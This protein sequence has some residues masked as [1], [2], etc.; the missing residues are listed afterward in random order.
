MQDISVPVVN[1]TI[2]V[3]FRPPAPSSPTVVLLHGLTGTSRWWSPVISHLPANIGLVVPDIRGRGQS[4]GSA[5]PFD[6]KTIADDIGHCLDHFEVEARTV[7]GYSMGAWVA[8]LFGVRHPERL[9]NILLVDGGLPV[10]FDA[11]LETAEILDRMVG[12]AVARLGMEFESLETYLQFWKDHPALADRW[13]DDMAKVFAYD[14][15]EVDTMWRVRGNNE[16]VVAGGSDMIFDDETVNSYR[17][18]GVPTTLI[19]VDHGMLNE[20]GGFITPRAAAS[21]ASLNANLEAT[22]LSD[23]NHYTLVVGDGA[24]SVASMITVGL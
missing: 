24:P 9:H 13:H 20:P 1:T 22:L 2:N 11:S 10:E 17:D 23:L 7:I 14:V 3:W 21:A 19:T 8:T 18:L 12:P 16:A 15:Q 6:L 5:G 4:W